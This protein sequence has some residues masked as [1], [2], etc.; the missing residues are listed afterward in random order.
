MAGCCCCCCFYTQIMCFVSS[1]GTS[2]ALAELPSLRYRISLLPG[3]L[4]VP[5]LLL[6]LD[7]S[8]LFNAQ[9]SWGSHRSFFIC[10]LVILIPLR[11]HPIFV[12][13]IFVSAV[14]FNKRLN[15]WDTLFSH[16]LLQLYSM[17]SIF[18][19]P[20]CL[21]MIQAWREDWGTLQVSGTP[22]AFWVWL[23]SRV[24]RTHLPGWNDSNQRKQPYNTSSYL[25]IYLI[26]SRFEKAYV[27]YTVFNLVQSTHRLRSR[28]HSWF[29]SLLPPWVSFLTFLSD[30]LWP[31]SEK[32]I[33]K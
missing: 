32:Q 16:H 5:V 11:P 14:C 7:F 3:S 21:L 19:S 33:P 2:L 24:I 18:S 9:W 1:P 29:L 23:T 30:K 8:Q 13:K 26:R 22:R 17:G 10:F 6:G 20:H 12:N 25:K 4:P 31:G 15:W 28:S 27:P